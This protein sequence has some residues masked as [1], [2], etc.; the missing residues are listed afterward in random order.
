VVEGA[1]AYLQQTLTGS[2]SGPAAS[3]DALVGLDATS[4]TPQDPYHAMRHF[5]FHTDPGWRRVD[6]LSDS[7]GLLASAWLSPSG[8][9]LT[10]ILVNAGS[11]AISAQ[12]NLPATLNGA[13]SQITRTTFAGVERSALL[14]SLSAERVLNVPSRAVVTLAL[15]R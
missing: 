2:S 4:F 6:A 12:L 13:A 11:A 1:S 14:G 5:A 15:S 3:P 7:E 8:D 9:A 10:L